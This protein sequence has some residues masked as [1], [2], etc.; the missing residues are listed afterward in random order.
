MRV[1][2]WL[3]V[4]K[5]RSL[6]AR[7]RKLRTLA[8]WFLLLEYNPNAFHTSDLHLKRPVGT[9]TVMRELNRRRTRHFREV[10]IYEERCGFEKGCFGRARI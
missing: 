3:G 6:P 5:G 7:L 10:G 2:A 8:S 9:V 1:R 4:T